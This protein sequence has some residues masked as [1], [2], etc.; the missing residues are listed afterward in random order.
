MTNKEPS[1]EE[2]IQA[3]INCLRQT[4]DDEADC[5]EFDKEMDCIAEW[6][7]G[8]ADPEQVVKPKIEAHI[9]QSPDCAEEFYSLISILKAEEEGKLDQ[10]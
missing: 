8:G 6:L 2:R 5:V 4:R 9:Q 3:L 10:L 1:Q 7:A